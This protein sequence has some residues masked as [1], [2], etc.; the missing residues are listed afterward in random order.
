MVTDELADVRIIM[1]QLQ[2]DL[3]EEGVNGA[4]VMVY[5]TGSHIPNFTVIAIS[6]DINHVESDSKKGVLPL[7]NDNPKTPES[8]TRAKFRHCRLFVQFVPVD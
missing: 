4:S 8:Q 6:D 2:A 5:D 7:V 1:S 3:V